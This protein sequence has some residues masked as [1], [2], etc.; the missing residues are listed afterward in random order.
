VDGAE[1]LLSYGNVG[2]FGRF[3]AALP[4]ACRRGD[5]LVVRSPRGQ[6]IGAVM[7]P[8]NEGHSRF[9]ADQ[10]VGEILRPATAG[11]LELAARMR[12]RS[13]LVFD[14]SRGIIGRLGFPLEVIDAEVLLDGRK[15]VVHYLGLGACDPRP[16][17]D[18]LAARFHLLVTMH[19]LALPASEESGCGSGA[20]GSSG[21]CGS[22]A[23]GHCSSC[24]VRKGA[25]SAASISNHHSPLV[26]NRVSLV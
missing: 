23:G 20:C 14:D 21:G 3:R 9:L 11:D 19:D 1:F 12:Q 22:C 10:F 17:I 18:Q 25:R 7:R 8:T 24:G 15:A 26:A 13:R 6:E 2:D 16:L 4:M 5:R